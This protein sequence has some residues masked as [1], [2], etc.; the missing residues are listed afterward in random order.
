[1]AKKKTKKPARRGGKKKGFTLIELLIVIAIIGIL[2]SI[3]LVSLNSARTRARNAS[4]K[5]TAASI[6]P[7]LVLCCDNNAAL[8][9]AP[10]A[11][12][13]AGG[14]LYPVDT[15]MTDATIDT[16]CQPDGTFQATITPGTSNTGTCTNAIITNTGVTFTNC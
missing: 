1:M 2:A 5:A 12:M 11:E 10:N 13:C 16:D 9:G 7:G 15:A 3:V 6:Q 4:F 8:L 14:D